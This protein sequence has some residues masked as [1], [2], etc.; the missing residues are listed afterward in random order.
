M[1]CYSKSKRDLFDSFIY[2]VDVDWGYSNETRKSTMDFTHEYY[3]DIY[4]ILLKRN[5]TDNFLI[6]FKNRYGFLK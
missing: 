4:L 6:I 2:K 5:S 1:F 3:F